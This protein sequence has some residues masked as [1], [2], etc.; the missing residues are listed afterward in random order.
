[1][2]QSASLV[3]LASGGHTSRTSRLL[4]FPLE[5]SFLVAIP[6]I[7]RQSCIPEELTTARLTPQGLPSYGLFYKIQIFFYRQ[8]IP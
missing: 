8:A 5:S 7:H 1:M 2:E 4:C 6:H 3:S